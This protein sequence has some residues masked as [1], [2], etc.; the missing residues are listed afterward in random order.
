[1]RNNRISVRLNKE[2]YKRIKQK[3]DRNGMELACYIR[4]ICLS[5]KIIVK[6]NESE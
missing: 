6:K 4:F 5:S 3:A 1:M 2:E